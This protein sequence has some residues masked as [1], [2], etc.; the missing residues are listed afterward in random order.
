MELKHPDVGHSVFT[1]SLHP[2]MS[3]RQWVCWRAGEA[4]TNGNLSKYPIGA[5]GQAQAWQ[6][7]LQWMTYEE[8]V[9][10]AQTNCLAG[11]GIVLPLEVPAAGWLVAMDFDGVPLDGSDAARLVEVMGIHQRLG[12]PYAEVSPSGRGI[13]MLLRSDVPLMQA[14]RRRS[15]TGHYDELYCANVKWVTITGKHWRGSGMPLATKALESLMND[16][17]SEE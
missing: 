7:P 12:E 6:T 15:S 3:L 16:W 5:N 11:V 4:R 13:R 2:L 9:Q 14:R 17:S 10:M 1:S 8:A